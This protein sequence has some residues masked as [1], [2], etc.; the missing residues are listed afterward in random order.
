MK[1]A[2]DEI[3]T[4]HFD[5]KFGIITNTNVILKH[6][7]SNQEN[8]AL[9]R[10]AKVNLIKYRVL[11]TNFA[12]LI[13][14]FGMLT[15]SFLHWDSEKIAIQVLLVLGV[16]LMVYSLNHK[17]YHYKLVIKEKNTAL[18]MVKASQRDRE[19]IKKFYFFIIKNSAKNKKR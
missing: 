19:Y 1:A 9:D 3:E 6:G 11:Y 13:L 8:I 14:S 10:I 2:L 7:N 4:L 17:F 15:G 18:H 12:L 5:N 16:F